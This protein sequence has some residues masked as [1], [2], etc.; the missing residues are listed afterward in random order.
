MS[1]TK[2]VPQSAKVLRHAMAY[3]EATLRM[4]AKAIAMATTSPSSYVSDVAL[5]SS[6]NIGRRRSLRRSAARKSVMANDLDDNA[7]DDVTD[8]DG[9]AAADDDGPVD[10]YAAANDVA[11]STDY[12][13]ESAV[14]VYKNDCDDGEDHDDGDS[15]VDDDDD[16]DDDYEAD[17]TVVVDEDV[18]VVAAVVS[19]G[20]VVAEDGR[21]PLPLLIRAPS[22]RDLFLPLVLPK[23]VRGP[24]REV[25]ESEY[26]WEEDP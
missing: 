2:S 11:S 22:P 21:E 6:A 8:D 18:N 7:D 19:V 26:D 17:D 14:A 1:W 5:F 16:D 24:I 12:C 4:L 15:E 23:Q 3:P 25:E 13:R 10:T 9:G 20:T